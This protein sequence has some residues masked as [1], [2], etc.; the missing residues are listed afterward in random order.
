MMPP[1][2]VLKSNLSEGCWGEGGRALGREGFWRLG[3]GKNGDFSFSFGF[4][5]YEILRAVY[6][7]FI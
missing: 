7:L 1:F 4:S 2:S 6:N 3:F 5:L